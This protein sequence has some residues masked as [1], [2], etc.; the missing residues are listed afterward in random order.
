MGVTVG[1][2]G[3]VEAENGRDGQELEAMGGADEGV[4]GG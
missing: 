1:K 2:D 3:S 4:V